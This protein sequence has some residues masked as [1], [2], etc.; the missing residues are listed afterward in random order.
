MLS[1]Y[2]NINNFVK[3]ISIGNLPILEND[4]DHTTYTEAVLALYPELQTGL[5]KFFSILSNEYFFF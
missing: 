4:F 3:E 2:P 1:Q 5:R